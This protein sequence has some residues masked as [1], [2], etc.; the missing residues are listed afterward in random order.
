MLDLWFEK[1][2]VFNAV[3]TASALSRFDYVCAAIAQLATDCLSKLR[4]V[5]ALHAPA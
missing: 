4:T 5:S 3:G 2:G 1:F